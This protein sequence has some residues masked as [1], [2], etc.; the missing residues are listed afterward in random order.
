MRTILHTPMNN[1]LVFNTSGLY[2]VFTVLALSIKL[3]FGGLTVEEFV[4]LAVVGL[5]VEYFFV[6][7]LS[8]TINCVGLKE[9]V[10]MAYTYK[11]R[12]EN[13]RP[14]NTSR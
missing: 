2:F 10:L 5:I 8:L 7:N 3:Y 12:H 6:T 13:S 4:S 11:T 14:H 9:F 1:F